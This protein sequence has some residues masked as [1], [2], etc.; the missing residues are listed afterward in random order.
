MKLYVTVSRNESVIEEKQR[1]MIRI[2]LGI[3]IM[4][5]G[6][7]VCLGNLQRL[8]HRFGIGYIIQIRLSADKVETFKSNAKAQLT[9]LEI[10]GKR[11]TVL[12]SMSAQSDVSFLEEYNGTLFCKLPSSSNMISAKQIPESSTLSRLLS[13]L[14][15]QRE[16]SLIENFAIRQTSLDQIFITLTSSDTTN[17]PNSTELEENIRATM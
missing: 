1:S 9:E 7:F 16:E 8:K 12:V 15:N 17:V 6:Q 2:R 13:F 5:L 11:G 3:G 14:E 10:C 4:K